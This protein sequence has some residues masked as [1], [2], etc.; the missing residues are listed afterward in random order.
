[1]KLVPDWRKA[2]SWFSVQ[3]LAVIMVLPIVWVGLPGDVKA[4]VPPSWQFWIFIVLGAAG[5]VGRVI[6]Q[7]KAPKP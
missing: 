7:N 5:I 6:D 3:A 2:W 4:W 1:M